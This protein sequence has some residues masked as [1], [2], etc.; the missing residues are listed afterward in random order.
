M[1]PGGGLI[2]VDSAGLKCRTVRDLGGEEWG[3]I[4]S[5]LD[6]ADELVEV[7]GSRAVRIVVRN[8]NA[9]HDEILYPIA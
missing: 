4:V 7:L 5:S 1:I 6:R 9:S 8:F 2:T 3:R